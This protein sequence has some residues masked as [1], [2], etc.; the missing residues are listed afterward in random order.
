MCTDNCIVPTEITK[1]PNSYPYFCKCRNVEKGSTAIHQLWLSCS[2]V[3]MMS[4][5]CSLFSQSCSLL[6]WTLSLFYFFPSLSAVSHFFSYSLFD[7]TT[8]WFSH[9]LSAFPIS[10][11]P[12]L[13]H[14]CLYLVSVSKTLKGATQF[15]SKQREKVRCRHRSHQWYLVALQKDE[16]RDEHYPVKWR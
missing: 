12:R 11:R 13:C 10:L 9:P 6:F 8:W 3:G 16:G 5:L 14:L 2:M 7:S 1:V 15:V 4:N